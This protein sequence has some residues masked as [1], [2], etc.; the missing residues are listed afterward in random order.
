MSTETAQ[1]TNQVPDASGRFGAYGGRYVPETLIRA[2]DELDA[3]YKAA[4]RDPLSRK[5]APA[6]PA[7][8]VG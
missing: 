3:Q 1:A 4:Q 6:A 8:V 2:L 5:L 7:A